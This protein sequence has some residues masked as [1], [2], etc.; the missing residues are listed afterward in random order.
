[1][2]LGIIFIFAMSSIAFVF[3]GFGPQ[4]ANQ[5]QPL[6]RF[7]VDGEISPQLENAYIQGGFTFLKFYYDNSSVDKNLVL[8]VEQAPE[9]FTTSAGQVQLIVLKIESPATYGR[10][11]NINGA[12][13]VPDL[14]REKLF[15]SLCSSLIAP[16][17]ECVIGRINSTG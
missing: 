6:D 3:T 8:F 2:A 10:I 13:D 14:N 16:P 4:P 7:V 9:L 5:L 11:V 1:M 12:V 17:V 15:D